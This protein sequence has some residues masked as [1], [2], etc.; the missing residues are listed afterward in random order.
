M[1]PSLPIEPK[2]D[3]APKPYIY[4]LLASG[5]WVFGWPVLYANLHPAVR[6]AAFY[7]LTHVAATLWLFSLITFLVFLALLTTYWPILSFVWDALSFLIEVLSSFS[8][9]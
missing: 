4:G 6:N 5:G 7:W 2:P 3:K 9:F 8:W 1:E